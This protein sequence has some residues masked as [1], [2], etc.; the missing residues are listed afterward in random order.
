MESHPIGRSVRFPPV[1]MLEI[2][3]CSSNLSM[4]WRTWVCPMWL[5]SEGRYRQ[6]KPTEELADPI[7]R[8]Y[9]GFKQFHRSS[10]IDGPEFRLEL[11]IHHESIKSDDFW[12]F[13]EPFRQEFPFS[14]PL[15]KCGQPR[16]VPEMISKGLNQ[17]RSE[18]KPQ[19][20]T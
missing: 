13:G 17:W 4:S 6:A 19:K 14:A 15:R 11:W 9:T 1:A 7:G 3:A 2:D 8:G 16:A 10:T 20:T 12:V 5:S 18:S